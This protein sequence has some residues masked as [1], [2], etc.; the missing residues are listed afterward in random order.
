MKKLIKVANFTEN[1][2]WKFI[3]INAGIKLN[4]R[5]NHKKLQ[6]LNEGFSQNDGGK[7]Y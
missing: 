4:Y 1:F 3:N 7:F 5:Q 6:H 2:S